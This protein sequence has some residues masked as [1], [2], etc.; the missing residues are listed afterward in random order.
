[1]KRAAKDI[2]LGLLAISGLLSPAVARADKVGINFIGGSTV[3]GT[4]APM[5]ANE[6][7]GW[8]PQKFWNNASGS[9]GSINPVGDADAGI[10]VF[11]SGFSASWSDSFGTRSTPVADNGGNSRLMKGYLN[12]DDTPGG[13]ITVTVTGVPG[14]FT[15]GGYAVVVYFDGDNVAAARV[16]GF[17]LTAPNFGQQTLYGLDKA[18]TDFGGTFKE[19]SGS[20]TSDL[21]SSTPDGNVLAFATLTDSAFTLTVNGASTSDLNPRGALNAIQIVDARLLPNPPGPAITSSG[22]ATGMVNAVFSYAISAINNPTNFGPSGLPS[23]LTINPT[24]GL[25]SGIP[26]VAGTF[27][28]TLIATNAN[29]SAT[30]PLTLTINPAQV[31]FTPLNSGTTNRLDGGSLWNSDSGL[32]AGVGGALLVTTNGGQT[33]KSLN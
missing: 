17:T 6:S 8:I 7:A 26:A 5:A 30:K 4:P 11:Y 22:T 23:G 18:N 1:M 10:S 13:R 27:Q 24:N 15:A 2:T 25:V 21:G 19:V 12:T 28:V 14:V 31:N 3:N 33:W 29:G 20:S 9:G 32:I 16:S